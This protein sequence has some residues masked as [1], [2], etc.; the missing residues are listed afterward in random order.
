MPSP[1]S[2]KGPRV[3]PP[4]RSPLAT[5][6][7]W[8]GWPVRFVLLGLI[9]GYQKLLSPLLPPSCRLYPCCSEY[10][11]HAIERHG[12]FKGTVLTIARV[13]RCNPWNKGGIDLVPLRGEWRSPVNPDGSARPPAAS[14]RTT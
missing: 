14:N 2:W 9:R 13:A 8:L 5:L 6:L 10:G 12:A 7:W 3:P 4:E 1:G 11:R